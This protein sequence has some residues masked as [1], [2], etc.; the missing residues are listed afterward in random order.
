MTAEIAQDQAEDAQSAAGAAIE[1]AYDAQSDVAALRQEVNAGFETVTGVLAGLAE[2]INSAPAPAAP[3]AP[4]PPTKE[5]KKTAAG[6]EE[7]TA[8]KPKRRR[9]FGAWASD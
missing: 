2:R 1:A 7:K 5:E 4:A 3:T 6:A 8:D 9:G